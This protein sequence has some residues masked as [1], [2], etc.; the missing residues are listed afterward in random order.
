MENHTKN[1]KRLTEVCDVY[2]YTEI[3]EEIN[4]TVNFLK[5]E[6]Y[7]K[8]FSY[9]LSAPFGAINECVR[10]YAKNSRFVRSLRGV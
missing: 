3:D 4:H 1:H 5:N 6:L 8:S 2:D 10:E 7:E 9:H